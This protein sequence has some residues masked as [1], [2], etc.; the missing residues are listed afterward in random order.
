LLLSLAPVS[1]W[2][3]LSAGPSG[4]PGPPDY[5][6]LHTD[7]TGRQTCSPRVIATVG[8]QVLEEQHFN[9]LEKGPKPLTE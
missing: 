1:S 7:P 9:D 2:L 4:W 8:A 6:A 3:I 5:P